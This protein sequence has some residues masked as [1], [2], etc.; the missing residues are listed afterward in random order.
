MDY[1][2]TGIGLNAYRSSAVGCT[3]ARFVEAF[4]AA[5]LAE[6]GKLHRSLRRYL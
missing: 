4:Y 2:H 5:P 1:L 3:T 6:Y